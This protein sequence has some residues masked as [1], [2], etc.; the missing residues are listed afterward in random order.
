MKYFTNIS[1]FIWFSTLL[2]V[3]LYIRLVNIV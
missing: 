1:T 2:L 3:L